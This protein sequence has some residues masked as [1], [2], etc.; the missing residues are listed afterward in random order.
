MAA[1][2]PAV[3]LRLRRSLLVAD[4]LRQA[5]IPGEWAP[6]LDFGEADRARRDRRERS[7]HTS[8][9]MSPQGSGRALVS[10]RGARSAPLLIPKTAQF[11]TQNWRS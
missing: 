1:A 3:S 5:P 6:G 11:G 8:A 10:V 7:R 9:G 2:R 4:L